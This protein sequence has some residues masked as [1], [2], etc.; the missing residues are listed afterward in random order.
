MSKKPTTDVFVDIRSGASQELHPRNNA[1]IAFSIPGNFL[2]RTSVTIEEIEK[3]VAI[4]QRVQV[5]RSFRVGLRLLH[6]WRSRRTWLDTL[7]RVGDVPKNECRLLAGEPRR[8]RSIARRTASAREIF[9][10][11][12]NNFSFR[13]CSW[14]RSTMVRTTISSRVIIRGQGRTGRSQGLTAVQYRKTDAINPVALANMFRR[15]ILLPLLRRTANAPNQMAEHAQKWNPRCISRPTNSR[16]RV[17][18]V[19]LSARAG[20]PS[21]SRFLPAD[22]MVGT[23]SIN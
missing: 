4:D 5:R 6:S 14:G 10:R 13:I 21:A 17:D 9:S 22:E 3:N 23:V 2:R 7:P 19:R 11:R 1:D 12:Q 16:P 20:C 18:S 8:N 15:E